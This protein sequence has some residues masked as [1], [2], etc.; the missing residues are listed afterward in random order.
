ML[1][2]LGGSRVL[3]ADFFVDPFPGPDPLSVVY[4]KVENRSNLFQLALPK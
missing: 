1:A 4:S 2:R 3:T